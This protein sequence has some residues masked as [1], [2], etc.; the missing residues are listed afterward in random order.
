MKNSIAELVSKIE[1]E[2]DVRSI[3]TSRFNRTF[4]IYPWIKAKLFHKLVLGKESLAHKSTKSLLLQF[5]SLFYG[6]WNLFI[7]KYEIWAFTN[8][9]ERIAMNGRYSDKLFDKISSYT[10]GNVLLIEFQYF[11]KFPFRK[12]LSKYVTSKALFLLSEEIYGRVFLRKFEVKNHKMVAKIERELKC[13]VNLNSILRKNLA[14]YRMMKF[15]LKILPKPKYVFM[16]VSYNHYGYIRA[17]KEAGIP[18]IEFQHGVISENHQAYNYKAVLSPCQFPDYVAVFG[19]NESDFLTRKSKMPIQ[20]VSIIGRSIIDHYLQEGI[21]NGVNKTICV[22]LQEGPIGDK[23]I[24]FLLDFNKN[25]EIKY[26]FMLV[27]R[28]TSEMTYR[29]SFDFPENF[30]FSKNNI[31][32]TL[33]RCDVSITAYST[34]ASEALSLGKTSI[35]INIDNKAKEVFEASLGENPFVY[36]IEI[37]TDLIALLKK[38]SPRKVE[39]ASSN[40]LNI[41]TDYQNNCMALINLLPNI[42]PQL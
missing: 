17:F 21:E 19:E 9:V 27:P 5:K 26:T 24:K 37:P 14:Q 42:K 34:V 28:R 25:S 18:L 16:S 4:E 3:Q 15:W 36:F 23:A 30:V 8:S 7:R 32:E 20:G 1:E 13:Q 6:T 35:L 22:A 31:Y 11:K 12:V 38:E 40:N 29:A 41:K 39:V 33:S 2:Y 10:K